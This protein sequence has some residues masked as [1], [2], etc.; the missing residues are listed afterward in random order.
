[1]KNCL[2]INEISVYLEKVLR[3]GKP[4]C[5]QLNYPGCKL[6]DIDLAK[7]G[8]S[9]YIIKEEITKADLN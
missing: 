5:L 8:F 6:Q 7:A 1:M 2:T 3:Q 4:I 9:I